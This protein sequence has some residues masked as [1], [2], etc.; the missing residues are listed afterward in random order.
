LLEQA[1]ATP[2]VTENDLLH[3]YHWKPTKTRKN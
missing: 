1:V 3:G 2:P